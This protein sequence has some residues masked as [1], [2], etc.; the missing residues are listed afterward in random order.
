MYTGKLIIVIVHTILF[1]KS[2]KFEKKLHKSKKV[3]FPFPSISVHG[4][5]RSML[6]MPGMHYRNFVHIDYAMLTIR[7][8][9]QLKRS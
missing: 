7:L 8:Q 1:T 2:V 9:C 6:T 3:N 4:G 5:S